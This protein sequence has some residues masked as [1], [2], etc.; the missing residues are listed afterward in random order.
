VP[1]ALEH[2]VDAPPVTALGPHVELVTAPRSGDRAPD[3]PLVVSTLRSADRAAWDRY[4][5]AH[6]DGTLFHTMPW[7]DAVS[8]SFGHKPH[9]LLANENGAMV[10]VLPSFLV[11]S[12]VLG[13]M[14]VSVPCGVGGGVLA[15]D[16]RVA[17]A[18]LKHLQGIASD[19]RCGFIDLRSE[20]AV[21]PDLPVV[22]R[23][24]GFERALPDRVEDVP[25]WLPRKARAA[26]RNARNKYGLTVDFGRQYLNTTWSLYTRT[27]RRLS[28]LNY[29]YRFFT[30][31]A[32]SF[33]HHHWVC[34][35]RKNGV[36]IAGLMTFLHDDRVMPY[37]FGATAEARR[38]DAGNL[39]YQS[40]MERGVAAGYRVFDFGRSR[41]DNAGSFNF[42]RF[43]GFEPRPLGYQYYCHPGARA[44]DVSPT[45]GRYAL[46][47]RAWPLLPLWMTRS[48]GAVLTKHIPG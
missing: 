21:F 2:T 45:S 16:G 24:A 39:I 41:Y 42:K 30:A 29:P 44:P 10:G 17:D 32:R 25:A 40:V 4:V 37:F 31:L 11:S 5:R 34:V 12:R 7:H 38:Y 47:R 48:L 27:M 18:L 26:A 43:C 9:Y 33:P 14:M 15:E 6:P 22:D 35:V 23:Y 20:R 13:R 28:S 8:D 19:R 3:R 46:V 1:D 36:P